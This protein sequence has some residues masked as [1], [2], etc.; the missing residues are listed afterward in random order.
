MSKVIK[1]IINNTDEFELEQLTFIAKQSHKKLKDIDLSINN[2]RDFVT[3]DCDPNYC[4]PDCI[5]ANVCDP[6]FCV[7]DGCSPANCNPDDADCNPDE[8]DHNYKIKNDSPRK[9]LSL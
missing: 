4:D 5:P 3:L 6:D 7:P 2:S 9:K 8:F 1:D